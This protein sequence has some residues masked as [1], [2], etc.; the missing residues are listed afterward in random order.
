MALA[1]LAL[2]SLIH[3]PGCQPFTS[4]PV[5]PSATPSASDTD[6]NNCAIGSSDENSYYEAEMDCDTD[7]IIKESYIPYCPTKDA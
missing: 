4:A 7:R 5:P 6:N 3:S 2:N 1:L